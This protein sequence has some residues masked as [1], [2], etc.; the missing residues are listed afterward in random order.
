MKIKSLGVVFSQTRHCDWSKHL[1][2]E[3]NFY[4]FLLDV[5]NCHR[6][7]LIKSSTLFGGA[8]EFSPSNTI[9]VCQLNCLFTW[10][11]GWGLGCSEHQ[12]ACS[13]QVLCSVLANVDSYFGNAT[14]SSA[15]S[16]LWCKFRRF[17]HADI[18]TILK[19]KVT[20]NGELWQQSVSKLTN[21][22]F[23]SR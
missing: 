19:W 16:K 14:V 18:R 2:Y 1:L 4:S 5:D 15:R 9:W 20:N 23:Y 17:T 6:V 21:M 12:L 7:D 13:K 10:A 3:G 11:N 22:K 8:F